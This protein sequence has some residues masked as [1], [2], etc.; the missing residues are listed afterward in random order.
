ME[1]R[2]IQNEITTLTGILLM[3]Y[4]LTIFIDRS[5]VIFPIR[6]SGFSLDINWK[7][8]DIVA[9]AAGL[10][11]SLGLLQIIH[12]RGSFMNK[13][14]LVHGIIP[15]TSA[16]SLGVVLRNTTVGFSW[17]MMLFFGGLLLFLVFTAE[18]I[19]VDPNDSRR[20]IAEIVL[21]G[22]A[23]STFLITSIA[24]RVNL[25]RLILELP[26]LALVAFLIALRLL[27]LRISG[28]KQEKWAIWVAI[29]VIQTA[30][31][32]HYW[33]INS[34]SYSVLMFLCFY[35]L[36]NSMILVSRGYSNSEIKKKQIVPLVILFLLW[37][38]TETVN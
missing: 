26:V 20:V 14:L 35:V 32:F 16:F 1:N 23:Y 19:M 31:A 12:E 5:I 11:S 9:P 17:W 21:T 13:E 15:F 30:T 28:V 24:V 25:S 7:M 27:F 33:P 6:I 22:L 8:I 10:L 29:F 2:K 18:T 37:I 34:L 36:V 38:L 3:V 4:V